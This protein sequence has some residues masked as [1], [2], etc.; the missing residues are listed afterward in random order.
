M[1]SLD[2]N[3][4]FCDIRRG[5][6]GQAT[7]ALVRNWLLICEFRFIAHRITFKNVFCLFFLDISLLSFPKREPKIQ[8]CCS[9]CLLT[10]AR[11]FNVCLFYSGKTEQFFFVFIFGTKPK[12]T[13]TCTFRM[14]YEWDHF[15]QEREL[16]CK[17]ICI[18]FEPFV[19]YLLI[20]NSSEVDKNERWPQ[21]RC[22]YFYFLHFFVLTHS[23]LRPAGVLYLSREKTQNRYRLKFHFLPRKGLKQ[24]YLLSDLQDC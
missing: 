19:S 5:L 18:L 14:L 20:W 11:P 7:R 23:P 2:A 17:F 8:K 21:A 22:F 24:S 1:E 15:T 16:I 6:K 9:C 13:R 10:L 12:E 4:R 3:T